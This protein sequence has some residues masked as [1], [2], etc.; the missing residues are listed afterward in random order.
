MVSIDEVIATIRDM[1]LKPCEVDVLEDCESVSNIMIGPVLGMLAGSEL[2]EGVLWLQ[3]QH[4]KA[5]STRW[6]NIAELAERLFD[7]AGGVERVKKYH[8]IEAACREFSL[9]DIETVGDPEVRETIL[10]VRHIHDDMHE[11]MIETISK[12]YRE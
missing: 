1:D 5:N 8:S 12:T 9:E 11:R 7:D 3:D 4:R 6:G 10:R 2:R